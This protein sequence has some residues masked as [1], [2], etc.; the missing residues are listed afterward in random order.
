[1]I[2]V[3]V[4]YEDNKIYQVRYQQDGPSKFLIKELQFEQIPTYEQIEQKFYETV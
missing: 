1:M 3:Y 4:Y 2:K